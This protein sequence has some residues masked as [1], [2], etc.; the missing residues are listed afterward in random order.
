MIKEFEVTSSG[1]IGSFIEERADNDGDNLRKDVSVG[2]QDNNVYIINPMTGLLESNIKNVNDGTPDPVQLTLTNP[3][4]SVSIFVIKNIGR[5]LKVTNVTNTEVCINS[6]ISGSTYVYDGFSF[7]S[8]SL[9]CQKTI[10]FTSNKDIIWPRHQET[11][12]VLDDLSK[13]IPYDIGFSKKYYKLHHLT[14]EQLNQIEKDT[15]VSID[16]LKNLPVL[17]VFDSEYPDQIEYSS[18]KL[19]NE[20]DGYTIDKNDR[21]NLVYS[22][23][24]KTDN[25]N[26]TPFVFLVSDLMLDY[27]EDYFI[28]MSNQKIPPSDVLT[29]FNPLPWITEKRKPKEK[30][31]KVYDFIFNVVN[32]NNEIQNVEQNIINNLLNQELYKIDPVVTDIEL[33]EDVVASDFFNEIVNDGNKFFTIQNTNINIDGAS[34]DNGLGQDNET[35]INT[36]LTSFFEVRTNFLYKMLMDANSKLM[37]VNYN[38]NKKVI[39]LLINYINFQLKN[40]LPIRENI[41]FNFDVFNSMIHSENIKLSNSPNQE[42]DENVRFYS[43]TQNSD[44]YIQLTLQ[45]NNTNQINTLLDNESIQNVF[46]PTRFITIDIP[47]INEDTIY[48]YKQFITTNADI[49]YSDKYYITKP[50][51]N[52]NSDRCNQFYTGSVI[53]NHKKYY[54]P[55]ITKNDIDGKFSKIFNI[56][57]AHKDGLG[58]TFVKNKT[59]LYPAKV[60]YKKYMADCFGNEDV[61][62]FKNGKKSEYFYAIEFERSAFKDRLDNTTFQ[63]SLSPLQSNPDQTVNTGSN[64]NSDQNSNKIFTLIDDSRITKTYN[65]ITY[66]INEYYSLVE[67]TIQQGL[68]EDDNLDIWGLV[69]PNKGLVILDGKTLDYSCSFNTVTASVDGDNMNKLFISISGSVSPNNV[70]TNHEY[71]YCRSAELYSDLNFFCRIYRNQFNYTN[72]YTYVSGSDRKFYYD[73]VNATSKTYITTIGLYNNEREL[74]AVAKLRKPL[75]KDSAH[76]YIFNIKVRTN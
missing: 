45:T 56:S 68:A 30:Y 20:W 33:V 9:S 1:Y 2:V 44:G 53:D 11:Q 28:E 43:I 73:I 26:Y 6:N 52:V 50:I 71:W 76:E 60:M 62:T 29:K 58:A 66:D 7:P 61:L 59:E 25:A 23:F 21:N 47:P 14:H 74:L 46:L 31:G 12:V 13:K 70:R 24:Y 40:G 3:T 72:N 54:L 57:Y 42:I 5:T 34:I 8:G 22:D 16:F 69:F 36:T 51:F 65:D 10:Y 39:K 4:G 19:S 27:I 37:N 18:V 41:I 48:S 38:I 64:F 55:V 17:F 35:D 75:L 49:K 63:I 15:R 67:G 32:D